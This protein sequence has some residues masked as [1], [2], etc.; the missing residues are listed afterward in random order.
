[1]LLL[2]DNSH[3]RDEASYTKA[4]MRV[5]DAIGHPYTVTRAAATEHVINMSTGMFTGIILSGS[6]LKLSAPTPLQEYALNVFHILRASSVPILGI[7][8]GAQ[9]LHTLHG[10]RLIDQQGTSCRSRPV[11]LSEHPLFD[12]ILHKTM[13]FCFSDLPVST[14]LSRASGVKEIAWFR[15]KSVDD[16]LRRHPCAFEFAE[17]RVFGCLFHPEALETSHVILRNFVHMC[18]SQYSS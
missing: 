12:G 1:M 7:C 18:A 6:P 14:S 10:G 4:L 2:V 11:E 13:K 3:S 5:L 9:L 15:F 17:G 16:R 8:F